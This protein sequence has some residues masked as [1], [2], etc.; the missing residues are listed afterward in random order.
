MLCNTDTGIGQTLKNAVLCIWSNWS[1]LLQNPNTIVRLLRL[2][3]CLPIALQ[4]L[5]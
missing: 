5:V 4:I 2:P 1:I 3:A